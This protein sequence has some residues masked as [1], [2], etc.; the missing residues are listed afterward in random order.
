MQFIWFVMAI[1]ARPRGLCQAAPT[2]GDLS[3]GAQQHVTVTPRALRQ[4]G[5][6]S[7]WMARAGLGWPIGPDQP[8]DQ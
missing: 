6:T 7:D 5:S 2:V 1:T 8:K 4:C 3:D